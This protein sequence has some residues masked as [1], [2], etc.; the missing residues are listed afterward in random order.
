MIKSILIAAA[1][2]A[3]IGLLVKFFEKT[4]SFWFNLLVLIGY[5]IFFGGLA[6]IFLGIGISLAKKGGT[7]GV[8]G[9]FL[10]ITGLAFVYGLFYSIISFLKNK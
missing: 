9:G 7:I 6:F 4:A 2:I 5:T 1:I 3:G 10:A 8:F